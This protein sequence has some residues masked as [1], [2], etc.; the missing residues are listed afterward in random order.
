MAVTDATAGLVTCPGTTLG[1]GEVMICTATLVLSQ[2]DIDAGSVSNT[3]SADGSFGATVV[4][5]G[6]SANV[7]LDPVPGI[8]VVKV[9][10]IDDSIVGPVGRVDPGDIANYTIT[11]ANTGNVTLDPVLVTDPLAAPVTCPTDALAPGETMD[12]TASVTLDQIAI[13]AGSLTNTV[14]VRG[15]SARRR[16]GRHRRRRDLLRYRD[17]GSLWRASDWDRQAPRANGHQS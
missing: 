1:S 4:S 16:S 9:G 15:E 13:D 11:V 2:A 6:A 10:T 5:D 7:V 8:G 14:S 12:C 3:A 17:P